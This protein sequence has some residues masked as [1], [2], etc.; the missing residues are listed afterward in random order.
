LA[1]TLL[2]Y[3]EAAQRLGCSIP[4]I[5]R[6]V[7][8]AILPSCYIGEKTPRIPDNAVEDLIQ[9]L[10]GE[11]GA[12]CPLLPVPIHPLTRLRPGNQAVPRPARRYADSAFARLRSGGCVKVKESE[13]AYVISAIREVIGRYPRGPQFADLT[14]ARGPD[15]VCSITASKLAS[16][17]RHLRFRAA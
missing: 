12:G 9:S 17:F 10:L 11:Q 15:T 5:R 2:T 13:P 3:E 14:S 6:M 4:H 8:A 1:T 16:Q 7:R